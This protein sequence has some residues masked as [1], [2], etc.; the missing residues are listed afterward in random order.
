MP[1]RAHYKL[2]PVTSSHKLHLAKIL[3][4]A[5]DRFE[6]RGARYFVLDDIPLGV[7]DGFAQCKERLPG[8]VAL[9]EQGFIVGLAEFLDVD[10]DG[11]LGIL[12]E[13]GQ[14]VRTAAHGVADIE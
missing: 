3:Q 9:S 2:S 14:G 13:I 8:D 4:T 1:L 12:V 6:R 11:P 5:F 7:A 10:G